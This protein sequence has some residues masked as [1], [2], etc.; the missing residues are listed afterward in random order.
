ML[1][2]GTGVQAQRSLGFGMRVGCGMKWVAN[3][4]LWVPLRDAGVAVVQAVVAGND[5]QAGGLVGTLRESIDC[6]P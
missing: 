2:F 3:R 4:I 5:R 6:L 1:L